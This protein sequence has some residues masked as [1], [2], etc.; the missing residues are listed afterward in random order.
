MPMAT[1]RA[2]ATPFAQPAPIMEEASLLERGPVVAAPVAELDV[3][4]LTLVLV[5]V[6]VKVMTPVEVER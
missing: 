6:R 5:S 3:T 1:A 2:A 4:V